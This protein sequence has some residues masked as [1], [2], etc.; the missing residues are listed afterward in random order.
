MRPLSAVELLEAWERSLA[1]SALERPLT[2]LAAATDLSR[3]ELAQ[4]SIGA[5]NEQL[6]ALRAQVFGDTPDAVADC[7]ACGETLELAL[8]VSEF[9]SLSPT[10][11]APPREFRFNGFALTYR[12]PDT[13]DLAAAQSAGNAASARE[14]LLQRVVLSEGGADAVKSHGMLD[15]PIINALAAQLERDDPLAVLR[16]E[17][18]CPQCQHAWASVLDVAAFLWMELDAW[19]KRTLREVHALASAYGWSEYE[20]LALSPQR[21]QLYLELIGS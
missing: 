7:P 21:R 14:L 9:R 17:L 2:L 13:N 1:Q 12:L 5:R 18:T 11:N 3:D 16:L 8:R 6:L 10:P 20:I 4:L 15:A 19:A